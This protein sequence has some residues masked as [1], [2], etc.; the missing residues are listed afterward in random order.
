MHEEH[1]KR[2]RERYLQ[3]GIEAFAPHEVLE[4]LLFYALPRVDTNGI[5]HRLIEKFGGFAG[6]LDADISDIKEIKGMGENS[7]VMLK[8]IGDSYNLYYKSKWKPRLSLL[9]STEVGAYAVD[10]IGD[11]TEEVFSVISLDPARRVIAMTEVERGSVS[12]TSI[13]IRKVVECVIRTRANSIILVHNH[14]SG[15]LHPSDSDILIT[16]KLI[17]VFENMNIPVYDHIIVAKRSFLSM[18]DRGFI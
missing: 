1:R 3:S 5:A 12:R 7:A 17:D 9:N 8:L 16:K 6:V 10:M 14:P 15:T 2:M 18:A 11:K 13:D 4:L